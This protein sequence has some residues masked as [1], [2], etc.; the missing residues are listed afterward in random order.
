MTDTKARTI[1][2]RTTSG[3][4]V[5]SAYPSLTEEALGQLKL[6]WR[7]AHER[8]G[9]FLSWFE[10]H[11]QPTYEDGEFWWSFGVPEAWPRG[12]PNHWA[13]HAYIGGPGDFARMYRD[14]DM[15]RF[16][17]PTVVGIDYPALTVRQ[18]F[19]DR[20]RGVLSVG[21]CRGSGATVVG[22]CPTPSGSFNCRAPIARSPSMGRRSPTGRPA[23]PARSRSG[24]RSTTT[25]S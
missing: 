25:T 24:R 5:D 4:R 10:Q 9:Q 22:G 15:R 19:W 7:L 13:A 2:A 17:E 6:A 3:P 20:E 14:A 21:I 1:V 12:I 11:Y 16:D 23:T 8:V 18:A